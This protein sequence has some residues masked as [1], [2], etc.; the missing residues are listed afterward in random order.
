MTE[1]RAALWRGPVKALLLPARS[2][3][4]S[5]QSDQRESELGVT[6][7]TRQVREVLQH[8]KSEGCN[9]IDTAAYS[10]QQVTLFFI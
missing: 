5:V 3:L 2:S 7:L 4:S 1:G 9:G 10:F 6:S 8:G